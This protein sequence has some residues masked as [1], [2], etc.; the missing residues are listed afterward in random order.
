M[1]NAMIDELM[2]CRLISHVKSRVPSFLQ[3]FRRLSLKVHPD[4]SNSPTAT[5]DFQYLLEA[6]EVLKLPR[7]P[8][9]KRCSYS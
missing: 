4:K 5:A 3:A 2:H 6:Y 9:T 7:I 8:A 1:I